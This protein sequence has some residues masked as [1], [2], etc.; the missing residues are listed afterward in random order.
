M[1]ILDNPQ[2]GLDYMTDS[3][4]WFEVNNADRNLSGTDVLNVRRR[5][6]TLRDAGQWVHI[7][8]PAQ[9]GLYAVV[10]LQSL[11][12]KGTRVRCILSFGAFIIGL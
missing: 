6:T 5:I 1:Q 7:D 11:L 8:L 3:A 4:G 10:I 2:E 9:S 12:G